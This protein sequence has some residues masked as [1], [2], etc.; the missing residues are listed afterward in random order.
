MPTN[1]AVSPASRTAVRRYPFI[2]A[3]CP[4]RPSPV[5]CRPGLGRAGD[6]PQMRRMTQTRQGAAPPATNPHA[7]F[8]AQVPISPNDPAVPVPPVPPAPPGPDLPE[9]PVEDPPGP[10]APLPGDPGL[11]PA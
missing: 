9:P 3:L 2:P 8:E 10:E 1:S 6:H 5:G 4:F 11:P 7:A